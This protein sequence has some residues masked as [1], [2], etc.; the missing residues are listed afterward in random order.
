MS[1]HLTEVIA[2]DPTLLA[3]QDYVTRN[4]PEL[5]SSC[6]FIPRSFG[7]PNSTSFANLPRGLEDAA[8]G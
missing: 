3:N 5:E 6:S 1:P 8:K 7:T 2:S 4:N